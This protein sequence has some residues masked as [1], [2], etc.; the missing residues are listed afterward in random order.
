MLLLAHV[1]TICLN[2]FCCS[3]TAHL[4]S[5]ILGIVDHIFLWGKS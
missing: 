4:Q 1:L 3:A 2:T 5:N